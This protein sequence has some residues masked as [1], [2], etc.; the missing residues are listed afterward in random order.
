MAASGPSPFS[1]PAMTGDPVSVLVLVEDS[2]AMAGKWV[3]IRDYYLPTLLGSLRMADTS[4]PMRVWWLTTSAAFTPS[5]SAIGDINQCSEIPDMKLMFSAS[6]GISATMLRRSID[7][8]ASALGQRRGTRHVIAAASHF[9]A[10]APGASTGQNGIDQTW[11]GTALALNQA[12]IRLHMILD[13]TCDLRTCDELYKR[14]LYLQNHVEAPVWF[15]VDKLR[16]KIYLSGGSLYRAYAVTQP[17][18]GALRE[19]ANNTTSGQNG[20]TTSAGVLVASTSVSLPPS[21]THEDAGP[22]RKMS[23]TAARKARNAE[24]NGTHSDGPGLVSYL[25]QMHGLT[26]KRSYGTKAAKRTPGAD[27]RF[28]TVGRPIL[29]RLEMPAPNVYPYPSFQA[30]DA[31][32]ASATEPSVS[33]S[34]KQGSSLVS[35]T[36]SD[37]RR[38]RRRGPWLP[39]GH[40]ASPIGSPTSDSFSSTPSSTTAALR[41]LESMSPRLTEFHTTERP[42]RR[43]LAEWQHSQRGF[44]DG[45]NGMTTPVSGRAL[46]TNV[47]WSSPSSSQPASQAP[48]PGYVPSLERQWPSSEM[49]HAP[50][51][52]RSNSS[53]SDF[54]YK[55]DTTTL[56]QPHSPASM[57]E[58]AE[59]QPF[60]VTPEY[61]AFVT[62]RFEQALRSGELGAS[63]T[64]SSNIPSPISGLQSFNANAQTR[65]EHYLPA[66][67]PQ[68]SFAFEQVGHPGQSLPD[69]TP[70]SLQTAMPWA[71]GQSYGHPAANYGPSS[72]WYAT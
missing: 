56:S 25:Q 52:P 38:A 45:V 64:S 69:L 2:Q 58:N 16:Y 31:I 7:T 44:G 48:S 5:T 61:E 28:P 65:Q 24:A 43:S 39:S 32:E 20:V 53:S 22:N 10:S 6:A 36:S 12:S 54:L 13:P 3:E 55:P 63:M 19:V 42:S 59:D 9:L 62:A 66:Y 49:Q 67:L 11:H 40:A 23:G 50:L 30:S 18:D 14:T 71:N 15:P 1:R 47:T 51:L 72:S 37:D 46:P 60:V 34:S 29:P 35:R 26:K 17:L 41:T 27:M 70:S 4:V 68:Q 8:F 57:S 21:P 33:P